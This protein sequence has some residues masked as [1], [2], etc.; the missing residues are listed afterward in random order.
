MKDRKQVREGVRTVGGRGRVSVKREE[1]YVLRMC[2]RKSGLVHG[3][4]G[5]SRETEGGRRGPKSPVQGG[6]RGT[7]GQEGGRTG[8]V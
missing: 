2:S 5:P 1:S 3:G 6:T 8:R 4:G 7:D